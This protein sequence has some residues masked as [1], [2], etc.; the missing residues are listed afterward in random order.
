MTY[1]ELQAAIK[2]RPRDEIFYI[3][4]Q[5]V[6]SERDRAL[7]KRRLHDNI[8]VERLAEEFDL[9]WRQCTDLLKATQLIIFNHI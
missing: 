7:I 5:Y 1:K 2:E 6:H 9:S 8:S 3:V 4:D